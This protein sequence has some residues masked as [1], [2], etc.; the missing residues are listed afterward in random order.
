MFAESTTVYSPSLFLVSTVQWTLN[1]ELGWRAVYGVATLL[2]E[3]FLSPI[4]FDIV[5]I[6]V[7]NNNND[8]FVCSNKNQT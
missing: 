3:N 6:D 8:N 7:S 2:S 5:K 1:K 4:I